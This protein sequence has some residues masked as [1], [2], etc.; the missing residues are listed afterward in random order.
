MNTHLDVFSSRSRRQATDLDDV[1]PR[2]SALD[3]ESFLTMSFTQ[4]PLGRTQ[5]DFWNSRFVTDAV[6]EGVLGTEHVVFPGTVDVASGRT[7]VS[8]LFKG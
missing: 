6:A 3:L 1:P 7:R 8:V 2:T 5:V 4:R